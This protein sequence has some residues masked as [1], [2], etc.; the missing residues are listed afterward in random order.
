VG[1][2]PFW[3]E[4][5]FLTVQDIYHPALILQVEPYFI[6]QCNTQL[7]INLIPIDHQLDPA[8]L[9]KLQTLYQ[10]Q[11]IQLIHLWED[12]WLSKRAQVLSRIKSFLGLNKG[13]HG[14][15]VKIEALSKQQTSLFLDQY[16]LQGYVKAKYNYGLV[17]ETDIVAV[18]SFSGTRAMRSKGIHY[19]SAELVRF[20]SKDGLTVVGG[21]SKLIKY[22]LKEIKVNDLMTYADR[23][24]SLGKGYLKLGLELSEITA[25][26]IL[27][28]NKENLI[29]YFP[30]RLPKE[31]LLAFEAQ[32][33][34]DLADFL[35]ANGYAKL[36]N[37][38]N[39]KYHLFL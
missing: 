12:I 31:I 26:A 25:P 9:I 18:G 19:Q 38:G 30:H 11:N 20:A 14:R 21:L 23:D 3:Q 4:D 22:F 8:N 36:F 2:N 33:Q 27:Y 1:L 7:L 17:V 16:H 15:K 10:E 35:T 39:L 13:I 32:N 37:T 24:W 34:L 6:I 5:F 29:R 28:V